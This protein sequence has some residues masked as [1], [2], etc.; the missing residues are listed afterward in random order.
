MPIQPQNIY[1]GTAGW[2]YKDWNDRVYPKTKSGRASDLAYYAKY[3]DVVEINSSFY[4]IPTQD[5]VRAWLSQIEENKRFKF[6]VKLHQGFTHQKTTKD[7]AQFKNA[8]EPLFSSPHYGAL[9][10]QFPWSYKKEQSNIDHLKRLLKEFVAFHC[11]VEFR[12]ASWGTDD[13]LKL[14]KE[15]QAVYVNIDQPVIGDSIRPSSNVTASIGY[16][17]LHGRNYDTWFSTQSDSSARYNYLYNQAEIEEWIKRIKEMAEGTDVV[18]V[19]FN[20]H[21][22]GQAAINALQAKAHLL[23]EKV[24]APPNLIAEYPFAQKFCLADS[25]QESFLF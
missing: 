22:R 24:K 18:F 9:L 14:L 10:I 23:N 13:T 12:H 20:N 15:H 5:S 21:F 19:I 3:F 8:F 16:V 17:R 6:N 2:S 7:V 11:A 1:L 4:K 25:V